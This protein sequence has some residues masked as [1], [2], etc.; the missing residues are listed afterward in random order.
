M[1]FLRIELKKVLKLRYQL[2]FGHDYYRKYFLAENELSPIGQVLSRLPV[3]VSLG[4]LIFSA[5]VLGV[6][7]PALTI[8]AGLNIQSV[9]NKSNCR[10]EEL[11][12]RSLLET[13]KGDLATLLNI[14]EEWSQVGFTFLCSVF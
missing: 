9:F 10:G 7:E 11:Q 13:S 12:I 8:A 14:Y 4:K 5:A 3:E 1:L 6:L 2:N